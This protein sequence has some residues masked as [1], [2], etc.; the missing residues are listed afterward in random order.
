MNQYTDKQ[1]AYF[2]KCLDS[3]KWK[4]DAQR[5][6]FKKAISCEIAIQC[7]LCNEVVETTVP[8]NSI[9]IQCDMDGEEEEARK[10]EKRLSK[11]AKRREYYKKNK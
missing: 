2:K 5:E 1:L 11:N 7:D 9:A 8:T 10:E 3:G 6:M 4:S